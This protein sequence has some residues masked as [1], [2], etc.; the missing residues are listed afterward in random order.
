MTLR[1]TL[2]VLTVCLLVTALLGAL[3]PVYRDLIT[4]A[5]GRYRGTSVA[6]FLGPMEYDRRVLHDFSWG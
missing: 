4:D 3:S 5:R 6:D 2:R 1:P